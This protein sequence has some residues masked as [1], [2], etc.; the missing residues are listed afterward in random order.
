MNETALF[1]LSYGV[2]LCTSWDEGRPVGCVANSAMQITSKPATVAVS[3]NRNNYTHRCITETG[4]FAVTVLAE[5]SDP[6]LIGK[7]GFS[8]SQDTD[9]FEDTPYRVRGKLP[10]PDG[11]LAYLCCKVISKMETATHTVFLGEVYDCDLIRSGKPMTYAYY[12]EVLKGKTSVNAPTYRGEEKSDGRTR[13][14]CTVCG[15][16]YDGETPFEELPDDWV[17]PM[18][19]VGKEYFKKI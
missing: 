18:C 2:Y 12:H 10:V 1:T 6:M 9:K 16:E 3:I 14:V 19:G 4:H 13:W 11:G 15:Y 17:C 7:F 5:N 8:S